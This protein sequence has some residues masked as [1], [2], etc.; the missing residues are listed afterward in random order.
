MDKSSVRLLIA[1][2]IAGVFW[3]AIALGIMFRLGAGLEKMS[4]IIPIY[5]IASLITS[6]SVTM[7]F[8]RQI[9][10]GRI[11]KRWWLPFA[12]IPIAV[13][14]WSFLVFVVGLVFSLIRQDTLGHPFDGF[15]YFTFY[16]LSASLTV[17]LF[18]IY[19]CAYLTQVLIGR[20]AKTS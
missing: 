3:C 17:Y 15:I 7:I 8:R 20:Y 12:T 9:I 5:F 10:D 19:P 6:Y 14:V 11:R 2:F 1:S 13:T 4:D 16:A 18:V